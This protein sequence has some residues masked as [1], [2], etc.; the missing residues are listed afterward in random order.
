MK[1]TILLFAL[2]L[3]FIISV[4]SQPGFHFFGG[5]GDDTF[6]QIAQASDGNLI[7]LGTK[8]INNEPKIWLLKITQDGQLIWEKLFSIP[9]SFS[10]GTYG[11]QLKIEED[12]NILILGNS[13]FA[14]TYF[15]KTTPD[16]ELIWDRIYNEELFDFEK[17]G[18][19]YFL[20]GI[21]E[22]AGV[23]NLGNIL[24][25]DLTGKSISSKVYSFDTRNDAKRIF[26]I[27]NSDKFLV[28]GRLDR[29]GAN[30]SYIFSVEMDESLN[31]DTPKKI[32]ANSE[33]LLFDLNDEFFPL[34]AC[35]TSE[36]NVWL[37]FSKPDLVGFAGGLQLL[38]LDSAGTEKENFCFP[39]GN[40]EVE[41]FSIKPMNDGSLLI[42]GAVINFL[43]SGK[44]FASKITTDGR[45]IWTKFYEPGTTSG[46]IIYSSV[47]T[48]CGRIFLAGKTSRGNDPDAMLIEIS[49]TG[50][51]SFHNVFIDTTVCIENPIT[52]RDQVFD[53]T[54][55]YQLR[56]PDVN[57]PDQQC[58]T[59]INLN[60]TIADIHAPK[61]ECFVDTFINSIAIEWEAV[62]LTEGYKIFINGDSVTTQT[63]ESYLHVLNS[64]DETIQFEVVP[65]NSTGCRFY[66]STAECSATSDASNITRFK[67]QI[68]VIPNPSSGVFQFQ[69]DLKIEQV[70]VLDSFGKL[71]FKS[72]KSSID[73]SEQVS[74]LYF[75]K[76][77]TSEGTVLKKGVKI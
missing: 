16:G 59:T 71:L 32:R 46:N 56:F 52:I 4:F 55:T 49:Q 67:N 54:G 3:N 64:P 69:T 25:T 38:K 34:S 40:L 58:D 72:K 17:K 19:K 13:T 33:P 66:S 22:V 47:E 37:A 36:N 50:E 57:N 70:E 63:F 31:L 14:G 60:L 9:N 68:S 10:Q 73:L 39:L 20:A 75:F 48:S 15:A 51:S 7:I 1:R 24:S 43:S 44:A 76:I 74:G 26:A 42:T 30:T 12:Q 61:I 5:T 11:T 77:K 6:T 18:D 8:T 41:P 35:L 21:R 45:L 29:S 2:T 27:N 62:P 65:F 28:L 23:N 53:Q